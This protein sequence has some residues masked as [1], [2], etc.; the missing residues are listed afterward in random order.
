[1]LVVNKTMNPSPKNIVPGQEIDT[2]LNFGREEYAY[3]VGVEVTT[4]TAV[5]GQVHLKTET[6]TTY[7]MLDEDLNQIY[8][9]YMD[10]AAIASQ[11]AF[12]EEYQTQILDIIRAAQ[13]QWPFLVEE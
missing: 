10:E 13:S 2:W 12:Y 8:P 6:A 4:R 1:M 11:D 3:H 9:A 7:I 5:P